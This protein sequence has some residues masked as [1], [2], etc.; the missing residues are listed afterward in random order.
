MM[1]LRP[2]SKMVISK[3]MFHWGVSTLA[4]GVHLE[5]ES[6]HIFWI[7]AGE[8]CCSSH[9]WVLLASSQ[10]VVMVGPK[11]CRVIGVWSIGCTGSVRH[12][13]SVSRG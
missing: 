6:E 12:G 5:G 8:S 7:W 10:A 2:S 11:K 3:S 9:G 4:E 13:G 1:P